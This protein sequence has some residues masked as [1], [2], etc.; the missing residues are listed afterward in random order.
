MTTD[1]PSY[2][3]VVQPVSGVD[4]TRALRAC[5]KSMLRRFGLRALSVAK[6]TSTLPAPRTEPQ[7]RMRRRRRPQAPP[8]N[9]AGSAP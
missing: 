5:L 2:V 6:N 9:Q 4:G 7:K 3:I 8:V 1:Q